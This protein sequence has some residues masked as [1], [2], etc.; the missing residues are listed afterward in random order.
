MIRLFKACTY[1]LGDRSFRLEIL[2]CK[3]VSG[4]SHLV[5]TKLDLSLMAK[6]RKAKAED[7]VRE[8]EKLCMQVERR[9][10]RVLLFK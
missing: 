5:K 7:K 3:T 1:K 2:R 10:A 9:L 8:D 6:V 4:Y